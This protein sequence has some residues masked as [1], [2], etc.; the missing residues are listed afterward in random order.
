M[1]N[2]RKTIAR[3]CEDGTI[4]LMYEGKRLKNFQFIK[5]GDSSS[6]YREVQKEIIKH[7]AG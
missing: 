6:V 5:N 2:K 1:I 7:N 3:L 4:F